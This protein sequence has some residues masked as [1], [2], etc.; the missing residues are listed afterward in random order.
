MSR[1]ADLRERLPVTP[2]RI[3]LPLNRENLGQLGALR[4]VQSKLI[5]QLAPVLHEADLAWAAEQIK[6][7]TSVGWL[8]F[9]IGHWTQAALFPQRK[10]LELCGQ[11]S[12]NLLN[13]ASLQAAASVSHL[14][15]ALFS[16]ETEAATLARAVQHFRQNNGKK[17]LLGLY[18]YGRPPLFT[19]RLASSHFQWQQAFLSPKQEL[20]FLEQQENLTIARAAQP[21]SLLHRCQ[22]IA[23]LGVDFLLVDLSAG[24][25]KEAGILSTLL[26]RNSS[27]RSGKV[28][29]LLT[30]NFTSTLV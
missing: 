17:L 5:W 10:G 25:R 6:R 14:R 7:L 13:S 30:G 16:L 19:S 21:F 23:A 24:V 2:Q 3:F 11:Y 28:P 4:K 26:G 1:A 9:S 29:E 15:A 20:F 18:A 12:L 22:D 8:R 27:R